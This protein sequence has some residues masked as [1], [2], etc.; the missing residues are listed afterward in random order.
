M[1]RLYVMA[2]YHIFY[3]IYQFIIIE[4]GNNLYVFSGREPG[5]FTGAQG[6]K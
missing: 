3:I 5:V 1:F 2:I 4:G 6:S